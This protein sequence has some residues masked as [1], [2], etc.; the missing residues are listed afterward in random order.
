MCMPLRVSV[1]WARKRRKRAFF[2]KEKISLL[3]L[4]FFLQH[5]Y[6]WLCASDKHKD[7]MT[8]AD[9]FESLKD[10]LAGLDDEIAAIEEPGADAAAQQSSQH[11][12]AM[13][14]SF[15]SSPS[16]PQEAATAGNNGLQAITAGIRQSVASTPDL[17]FK[18]VAE[19]DYCEQGK[20]SFGDG[21]EILVTAVDDAQGLYLG[22][23]KGQMGWFPKDY[24]SIVGSDEADLAVLSSFNLGDAPV[25]GST[26]VCFF[27]F[28][29]SLLFFFFFPV[30]ERISHRQIVGNTPACVDAH[31]FYICYC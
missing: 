10:L 27:L 26:T 9:E 15:S 13:A 22:E 4:F 3:L 16:P 11:L 1:C 5:I 8:E 12:D 25:Q 28:L 2:P 23:C 20:L 21:D 31:Q 17:P 18:V 6:I 24:C 14:N 7:T 19:A 29:Y 30:M